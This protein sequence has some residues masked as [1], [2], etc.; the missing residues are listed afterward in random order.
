MPAE[1]AS[2][3]LVLAYRFQELDPQRSGFVSI[4]DYTLDALC[5]LLTRANAQA[6]EL[7]REQDQ[8]DDDDDGLISIE[9]FRKTVRALGLNV[10]C[11]LYTS[12]SPRDS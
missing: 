1:P 10:S 6:L 5:R 3:E 8:R 12:P 2:D 7:F 4:D 11:L 9:D